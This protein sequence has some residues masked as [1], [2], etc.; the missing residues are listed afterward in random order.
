M[1]G[2]A[3]KVIFRCNALGRHYDVLQEA[4]ILFLELFAEHFSDI[5]VHAKGVM[6]PHA[7]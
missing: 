4:V 2:N 7:S 3:L 6:Q 1:D 5:R